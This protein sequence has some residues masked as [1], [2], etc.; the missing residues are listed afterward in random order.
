[1]QS[2][3]SFVMVCGCV[4]RLHKAVVTSGYDFLVSNP[5]RFPLPTNAD[6]VSHPVMAWNKGK[7]PEVSGMSW[8]IPIIL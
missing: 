4:D 6:T 5:L 1:M 3:F 7:D 8:K 2:T